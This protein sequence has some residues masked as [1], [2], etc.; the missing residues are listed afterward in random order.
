MAGSDEQGMSSISLFTADTGEGTYVGLSFDNSS[1]I[2]V[3]GRIQPGVFLSVEEARSLAEKLEKVV[4]SLSECQ[5]HDG[6]GFKCEL[7]AGHGGGCMGQGQEGL[8]G[9]NFNKV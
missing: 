7:G 1:L 6:S 3:D 5:M 9:E 4:A 8:F 2:K